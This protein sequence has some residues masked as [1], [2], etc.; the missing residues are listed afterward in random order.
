MRQVVPMLSRRAAAALPGA[1]PLFLLMVFGA[2]L[3]SAAREHGAW[4]G[5]AGFLLALLALLAGQD[6]RSRTRSTAVA[7]HALPSSGSSPFVG[8]GRTSPAPD[9]PAPPPPPATARVPGPRP[10]DE[11]V[12]EHP[13]FRLDWTKNGR[14]FGVARFEDA[15]GNWC[16]MQE[17]SS[18][19][20]RLWLGIDKPRRPQGGLHGMTD[21]DYAFLCEKTRR[22][23][24]SKSQALAVG[25]AMVD[26]AEDEPDFVLVRDEAG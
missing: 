26:W 17:S 25:R 16:S 5:I 8:R 11:T 18:A 3:D 2:F 24:L 12:V 9:M 4:L 14:G 6:A 1:L 22:M 23:H 7:G 21:A 20:P 19:M 10:G 13:G 15:N